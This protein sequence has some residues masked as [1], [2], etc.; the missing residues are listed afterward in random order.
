MISVGQQLRAARLAKKLTLAQIADETHI[1]SRYLEAIEG[2]DLSSLPGTFFYQSWVK[3]YAKLVGVDF[4]KLKPFMSAQAPVDA[5]VPV[6]REKSYSKP[7]P[8]VE[9]ING[10]VASGARRP[11]MQLGMLVLVAIAGAAIYNQ[12]MSHKTYVA[13]EA[14]RPVEQTAPASGAPANPQGATITPVSSQPQPTTLTS[15]DLPPGT[16]QIAATDEVW[17]SVASDNNVLF[18]GVLALGEK[19]SFNI[20]QGRVKIGNAAGLDVTWKGK[21]LGSLGDRGQVR[22]LQLTQDHVEFLQQK[23]KDPSAQG[24]T[25]PPASL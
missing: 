12:W 5:D 6:K 15:I 10:L 7:S 14:A 13:N 11:V 8:V 24:T 23:P 2:D 18:A 4:E 19:R 17:V 9:A 21:S 25:Q 1:G 22:V 3:Q 16:L 20:E